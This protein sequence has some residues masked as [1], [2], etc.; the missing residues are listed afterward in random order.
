M[1]TDTYK[2]VLWK[3]PKGAELMGYAVLSMFDNVRKD[4]Y[5]PILVRYGLERDQIEPEA[6]Y[7][8]QMMLDI[9]VEATDIN[10]EAE[11]ATGKAI[12]PGV[13]ERFNVTDMETFLTEQVNVIAQET[14]RNVPREYGYIVEQVG[15]KH[16]HITKNDPYSNYMAFGYFWEMARL[17]LGRQGQFTFKPIANFDS[18]TQGATFELQWA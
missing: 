5:I 1:A 17:L 9:V 7:P 10:N 8:L 16:Y 11:I 2:A 3:A 18:T 13:I 14:V 12:A 4:A 6:W 15:A